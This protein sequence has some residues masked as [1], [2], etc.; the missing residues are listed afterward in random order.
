MGLVARRGLK[1]SRIDFHEIFGLEP[2][3]HE[4]K[5]LRPRQKRSAASGVA[6]GAP[7][8]RAGGRTQGTPRA[9]GAN[10]GRPRLAFAAR[11]GI[12]RATI[13]EPPLEK[14]RPI[15]QKR[16]APEFR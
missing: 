9:C 8:R 3:A 7:E 5:D 14:E 16:R 11:I 4:T 13:A 12:R 2:A 15:A 10:H 1:R 6:V